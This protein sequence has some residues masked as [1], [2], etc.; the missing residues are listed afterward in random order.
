MTQ[1]LEPSEFAASPEAQQIARLI[2][3]LLARRQNWGKQ[4]RRRLIGEVE[5]RDGIERLIGKL[6]EA[7]P[8]F[9]KV[10]VAILAYTMAE[11]IAETW[12]DGYAMGYQVGS[13]EPEPT[14]RSA[15]RAVGLDIGG[16]DPWPNLEA[17]VEFYNERLTPQ[18][19]TT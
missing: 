18:K 14:L 19:V 13:A 15:A 4:P 6:G 1:P 9:W 2:S 17:F 16:R 7:P 12:E 11:F 8:R 5:I 3:E 10:T